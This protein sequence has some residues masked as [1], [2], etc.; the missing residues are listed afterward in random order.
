[1]FFIPQSGARHTFTFCSGSIGF[2]YFTREVSPPLLTVLL[3]F[4]GD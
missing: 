4:W 1:M 3:F 2:T